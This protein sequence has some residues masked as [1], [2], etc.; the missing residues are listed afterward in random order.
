MQ[1]FLPVLSKTLLFDG[2]TNDEIISIL[3][4][5]N[6]QQARYEKGH[7]IH[8]QG[9]TP[10]T[11]GIILQGSIQIIQEDFWGNRAILTQLEKTDL[12]GEAFCCA[13]IDRLPISIIT[14]SD[15]DVLLVDYQ[16]VITSCTSSCLF[17]HRLISNMLKIIAQK[18]VGLMEKIQHLMRRGSREKIL[19]YLSGEARRQQSNAFTIPFNRQ[20]LADYLSI[21]RSA[22]SNELSKMRKE[23]IIDF[24]RSYF[25]LHR[26][27]P[28]S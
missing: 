23:G 2:L 16:K 7:F 28:L 6:A 4:C 22:L 24:E 17:H 26:Y 25:V 13:Q 14:I 15:C 5:L 1:K 9:D 20:E 3:P 11:V 27:E 12:F 21:D 18:N 8:H 19:S 10:T